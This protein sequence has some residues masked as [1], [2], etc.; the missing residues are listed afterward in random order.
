MAKKAKGKIK[1]SLGFFVLIIGVVLAVIVAGQQTNWFNHAYAPNDHAITNLNST[2]DTLSSINT[3]GTMGPSSSYGNWSNSLPPFLKGKLV[4]EVIDP[5]QG[6]KPSDPGSQGRRPTESYHQANDSQ[7][8]SSGKQGENGPQT[9][10][11]LN[12]TITKVEV[13]IAYHGKPGDQSGGGKPSVTPGQLSENVDHWETLDI[14]TP[15]TIDLVQLAKTKDVST[16]GITDLAEGK[17]TEVRL[18]ISSATATLADGSNVTVHILGKNGTVRVVRPFS[19]VAGETTKLTMDFDAQHSVIK[20]G[21]IYLLKPVV[22]RL[23]EE[24]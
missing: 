24:K 3:D 18:Y 7:G 16:L 5:P 14:T 13:H 15:A 21:E 9:L 8:S 4:F 12:V 10:T 1:I 2:T 6:G 23:L 17:Y 22:S 19:V 11:A 20:A